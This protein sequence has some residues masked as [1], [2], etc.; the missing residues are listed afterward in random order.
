MRDFEPRLALCGGEDGYDFYR[1]VTSRWKGAL[2]RGGRLYCEVGAGQAEAVARLMR[3][4][5]FADTG[6]VPDS[7]GIPR[8]VYGTRDNSV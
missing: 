2:K 8:V 7:Q 5:R 1:A 3:S 6:I 4:E